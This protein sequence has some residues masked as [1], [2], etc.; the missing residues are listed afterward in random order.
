M[1]DIAKSD[2]F[3]FITSLSV[4]VLTIIVAVLL[5]YIFLIVRNVKGVVEKVK[6]E[7]DLLLDDVK[8]LRVRLKSED[9]AIRRASALFSFVRGIFLDKRGRSRKKKDEE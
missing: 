9:G 1:A 2:I 7:S 4:V 3:F 6:E 5:V 8:Q